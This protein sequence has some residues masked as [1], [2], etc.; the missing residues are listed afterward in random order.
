MR[1]D[2]AAGAGE[3]VDCGVQKFTATAVSGVA[4]CGV[5][6]VVINKDARLALDCNCLRQ[7]R[8]GARSGPSRAQNRRLLRMTSAGVCGNCRA[9][10]DWTAEGGCPYV[11]G[12][13]F[14]AGEGARATWAEVIFSRA[15]VPAP[16]E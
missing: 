6:W 15:G 2:P 7:L 11:G 4:G 12:G 8:A 9:A 1:A 5:R 14:F 13:V 16:H 10:L 3:R